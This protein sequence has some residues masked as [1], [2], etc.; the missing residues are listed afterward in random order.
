MMKFLTNILKP[1]VSSSVSSAPGSSN[2]NFNLSRFCWW[3]KIS[4]QVNTRVFVMLIT[5]D[6]YF[7]Q[8]WFHFQS[9]LYYISPEPKTWS[10]SRDFCRQRGAD[11]TTIDSQAEQV[12]GGGGEAI[13]VWA[14]QHPVQ[15]GCSRNLTH[16]VT[17]ACV[18]F[19]SILQDF[20]GRFKRAVWIG[21]SDPGSDGG[22]RWVDGSPLTQRSTMALFWMQILLIK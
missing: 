15:L 22:W 7:Q 12:G 4:D 20:V 1:S 10:L 16:H 3:F 11:L 14:E 13:T 2:D 8:G 19:L 21:L 5:T 17:A 6:P 9:S 18:W